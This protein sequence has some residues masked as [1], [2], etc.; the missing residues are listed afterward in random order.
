M[1]FKLRN[2]QKTHKEMQLNFYKILII[3]T[4]PSVPQATI[5]DSLDHFK[6][7]K[8]VYK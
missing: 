4:T 3:L 7:I 6:L 2:T 8:K 5:S 1:Y